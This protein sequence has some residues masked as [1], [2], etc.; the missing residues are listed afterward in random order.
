MN[1]K[2]ENVLSWD[3]YFMGIAYLSGQR[4]KDPVTQ[5]GACII[6]D[7]N[8]I[9]GIGYNGM[10]EGCHDDD[11]PWTKDKS[12]EYDARKHAY[13]CH[14]EMNAILNKNSV[15]LKGCTIYVSLF[16]CNE[17]AKLIIQSGIKRVVYY[18][19]KHWEKPS[20]KA[21]KKML[22]AASI[23]YIQHKSPTKT[24]KI[25]FESINK[26]PKED[27]QGSSKRGN[28]TGVPSKGYNLTEGEQA[29]STTVASPRKRKN[30]TPK[31]NQS[32]RRKN[33]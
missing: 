25:N 33:Q 2:R 30:T 23:K 16:P 24:I 14:A 29:A 1:R 28:K 15:S 11:F 22:R 32:K 3:N 27:K 21:S 7:E 19:D 6:N 18:S 26:P 4:S 12:L 5:V 17:C 20:T 9:V 8:R 31:T 13:V 10:P